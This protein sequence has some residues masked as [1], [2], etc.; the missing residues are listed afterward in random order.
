[1]PEISLSTVNI[2][3]RVRDG[4][5]GEGKKKPSVTEGVK[6]TGYLHDVFGYSQ[7]IKWASNVH[8]R[9]LNEPSGR[10]IEDEMYVVNKSPY[11]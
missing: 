1:M 9:E 10:S 11:S 3:S 4:Q 2:I 7:E 8:E 5:R 6:T